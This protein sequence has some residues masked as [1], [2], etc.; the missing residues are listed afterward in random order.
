MSH[1]YIDYLLGL[2]T[3][4]EELLP[5]KETGIDGRVLYTYLNKFTYVLHIT[6]RDGAP[7]YQ[8]ERIMDTTSHEEPSTFSM[9]LKLSKGDAVDDEAAP[10]IPGM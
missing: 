5:T 3:T 1:Y 8:C 6:V 4:T 9:D 2:E 10:T 7:V